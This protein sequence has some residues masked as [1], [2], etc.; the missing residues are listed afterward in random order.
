MA[1]IED[2]RLIRILGT[3]R[4]CGISFKVEN[5]IIPIEKPIPFL[6]R[7][8]ILFFGEGPIKPFRRP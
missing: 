5:K 3:L 6:S 8:K 4:T 7:V 1:K 2:D